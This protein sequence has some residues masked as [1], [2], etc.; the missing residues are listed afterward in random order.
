MNSNNVQGA[1]PERIVGVLP[2]TDQA[3]RDGFSAHKEK[4][5]YC[6]GWSVNLPMH[7]ENC[8]MR[9]RMVLESIP[10]GESWVRER[11]ISGSSNGR[12]SGLGPDNVGSSPALETNS[13][14]AT[15]AWYREKRE[16]IAYW[17]GRTPE[18][19]EHET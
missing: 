8:V 6:G 16:D 1:V 18:E 4:C 13:D 14:A 2:D 5:R 10:S 17:D 15:E 7:E 9:P 11:F 12:T 19:G 3:M